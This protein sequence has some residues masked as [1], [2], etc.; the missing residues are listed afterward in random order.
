VKGSGK[1]R[2]KK[3]RGEREMVGRVRKREEE[4]NEI[5]NFHR[6]IPTQQD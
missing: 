1:K 6:S 4:R 2:E 3:E 5:Y